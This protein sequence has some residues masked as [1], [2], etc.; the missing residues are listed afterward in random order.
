MLC[1]ICNQEFD[2]GVIQDNL[3]YCLDHIPDELLKYI[4]NNTIRHMIQS[5]EL[6]RRFE[7]WNKFDDARMKNAHILS[8]F[9]F[10]LN[11]A[12][13]NLHR[14]F[15]KTGIYKIINIRNSTCY[16]GKTKNIH[17]RLV[18]HLRDLD[19][20]KHHNTYLQADYNRY[21]SHCFKVTFL[22]T[23]NPER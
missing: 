13:S 20:N 7:Q 15:Y 19:K 18:E 14:D 12:N 5:G 4:G 8:V 10:Q 21:G 2:T 11:S 16:I 22:E 1:T 3:P 6:E 17:E 23:Y 9:D